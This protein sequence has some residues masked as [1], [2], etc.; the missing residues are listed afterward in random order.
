MSTLKKALEKAKAER[1][2]SLEVSDPTQFLEGRAS[3]PEGA[4]ERAPQVLN[5]SEE[6]LKANRVV[7]IRDDTP[8]AETF[9]LLRT[10]V[11][12][13]I[14]D[15]GWKLI[16][17]SGFEAGEGK[18]LVAVNLAVAMAK[19]TR[20]TTVLVDLDFRNPSIHRLLAIN[21]GFVGLDAYFNGEASLEDVYFAAGIEKLLLLPTARAL[22]NAPEVL[23]SQTMDGFIRGLREQRD[24]IT[25]IDTPALGS[26]PDP[27]IVS[28]YVDCLLLVARVG[29]TLKNHI[30]EGL[31]LVP[32]EKILGIVLNGTPLNHNDLYH[33]FS[34][35]H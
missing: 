33:S 31:A 27:L 15:Q 18:S 20:Q 5:L 17:V 8:Y 1:L 29:T 28:E 6:R 26:C 14:R 30:R 19:D 7:T 2:S 34:R 10:R 21:Q 11:L 4:S 3:M 16:Q 12:Q 22:V 24:H 25:I 32:R 35:P 13:K 23:G 9:K